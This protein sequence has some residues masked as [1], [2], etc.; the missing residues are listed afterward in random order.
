[1]LG[2]DICAPRM[3][4]REEIRTNRPLQS[5]RKRRTGFWWSSMVSCANEISAPG[6][7]VT[8]KSRASSSPALKTM[9][10]VRISRCVAE[11]WDDKASA[12]AH[13]QWSDIDIGS[14]GATSVT[15]RPNPAQNWASRARSSASVELSDTTM[16]T[17]SARSL[18]DPIAA[19]QSS[20]RLR[21]GITI[22]RAGVSGSDSVTRRTMGTATGSGT[23]HR[24]ADEPVAVE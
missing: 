6:S 4:E 18:M 19:T 9:R 12:I 8:I 13:R 16:A 10:S 11:G 2:S 15:R 23:C 7:R 24:A 20:A 14:G 1:M 22:N 17:R 5:L 3:R 21:V